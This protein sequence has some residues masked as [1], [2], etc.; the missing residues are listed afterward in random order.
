M[1]P[2]WKREIIGMYVLFFEKLAQL[3]LNRFVAYSDL[4]PET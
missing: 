1:N 3:S 2:S 4:I